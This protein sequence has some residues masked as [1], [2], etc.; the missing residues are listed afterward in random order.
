MASVYTTGDATLQ[1]DGTTKTGKGFDHL[2]WKK[3]WKEELFFW[4][5]IVGLIWTTE[6]IFACQQMVI[7]GAVAL[8]F[9]A[10]KAEKKRMSCAVCTST[11]RLIMHHLGSVA[12]GSFIITLVK[13]PR[14][15]LMYIQS[16]CNGS[17]SELAKC[18]IKCCICCLWCLEKALKFLNANA[19]T[20][21]AIE[22]KNFCSAAGT[23]FKIIASNILRVTAINSVGAFVLFL[24]KL[25][26]SCITC[27]I[28]VFWFENATYNGEHL[29][30]Y[31][32]P[33]ALVT[34]FSFLVAHC[35]LSIYEMVVDTM[36]LCFCED[37]KLNDGSPEKPYFM[38]NSLMKYVKN[39]SKAL[40]NRRQMEKGGNAS[41]EQPPPD[42]ELSEVQH[43]QM[44]KRKKSK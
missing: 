11:G 37:C 9:F 15:I 32:V 25:G 13:I 42:Y 10:S 35:F 26:V 31:A 6:F 41:E 21:I 44:H 39:S 29:Y 2:I 4:Y 1:N 24:G 33:V 36:L 8:W 30:M 7:S 5:H 20:V 12:F 40:K 16:K 38:S 34:I 22:G 19:Y 28:A 3:S 14:Y 27:I 17:E 18:C 23:A 43:A